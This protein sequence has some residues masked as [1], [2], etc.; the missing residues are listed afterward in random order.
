MAEPALGTP[1]AIGM[2]PEQG[3][4]HWHAPM[5]V[6]CKIAYILLRSGNA[7]FHSEMTVAGHCHFNLHWWCMLMAWASG[8]FLQN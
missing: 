8:R 7:Q 6:I 3:D 2:W 5:V 1:L 4:V